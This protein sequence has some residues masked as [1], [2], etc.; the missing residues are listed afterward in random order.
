MRFFYAGV[1]FLF[2]FLY[3][4]ALVASE[5]QVWYANSSTRI[6]LSKTPCDNNERGYRAAAQ[7]I[8]NTFVKGCWTVTK[9]NMI[10][11]RWKDGDFTEVNPDLFNEVKQQFTYRYK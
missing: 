7:S 4:Y 5:L 3:C 11:I 10:K 9:E 2:L 8:D 1:M 6:V